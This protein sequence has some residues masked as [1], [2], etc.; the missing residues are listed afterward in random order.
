M[1]VLERLRDLLQEL[2]RAFE[3]VGADGHLRDLGAA[4]HDH[5]ALKDIDLGRVGKEALILKSA[6]AGVQ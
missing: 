3:G 4:G 6:V 5:S 2:R 1:A